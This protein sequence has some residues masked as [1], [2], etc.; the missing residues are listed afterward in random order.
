MQKVRYDTIQ[1]TLGAILTRICSLFPAVMFEIV[2]QASFLILFLWL[3]VNKLNKQGST[4]HSIICC[5]TV[6]L[7][8]C[9]YPSKL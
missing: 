8:E 2:Q 4:P 9:H 7:C 6:K 1:N 3:W 5:Q